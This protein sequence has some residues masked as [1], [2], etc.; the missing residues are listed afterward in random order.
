MFAVSCTIQYN[1]CVTSKTG[2][3]E[4]CDFLREKKGCHYAALI[5]RIRLIY[6]GLS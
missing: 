3:L 2:I 5:L 4:K 6:T 1:L